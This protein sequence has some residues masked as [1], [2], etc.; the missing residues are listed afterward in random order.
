LYYYSVVRHTARLAKLNAGIDD[1]QDDDD[2]DCEEGD[3]VD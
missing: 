2:E 3:D 1:E